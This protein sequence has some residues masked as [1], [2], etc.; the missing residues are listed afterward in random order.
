MQN[1]DEIFRDALASFKNMLLGHEA[2]ILNPEEL[3][4]LASVLDH[5]NFQINL[6]T[7]SIIQTTHKQ[8]K[9]F[10]PRC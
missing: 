4:A 6:L 2:T 8:L 7:S 9:L 1:T 5:E 3:I 10:C